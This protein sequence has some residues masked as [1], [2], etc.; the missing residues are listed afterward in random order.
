M[1]V[2]TLYQGRVISLRPSIAESDDEMYYRLM[3]SLVT[4][5]S[6]EITGM[7]DTY[8][9][10]GIQYEQR[11]GHS[12]TMI[13]RRVIE[14]SL[15][16]QPLIKYI[17][18]YIHLDDSTI[19]RAIGK[20]DT[21]ETILS[22][23]SKRVSKD[24]DYTEREHSVLKTLSRIPHVPIEYHLNYGNHGSILDFKKESVDLIDTLPS[25]WTNKFQLITVFNVLHK[26]KKQ[27]RVLRELYRVLAP[28]GL[29]LIHESD[30]HDL[31]PVSILKRQ[32]KHMNDPQGIV[33]DEQSY[34]MGYDPYRHFL[35]SVSII[36]SYFSDKDMN[37]LWSLYRSRMEWHSL[38]QDKGFIH[39]C[40]KAD[41]FSN[42]SSQMDMKIHSSREWIS[43]NPQRI[44]EGVYTKSTSSSLILEYHTQRSNAIS[45][46]F[47]R[48]G[49]SSGVLPNIQSGINYDEETLSYMTPWYAAQQ[50][51]ILISRIIQEEYKVSKYKIY[52]GTGGSGGNV[53]AYLSNPNISAIYVYERVSKFFTYLVNNIQLYTGGSKTIP[54]QDNAVLIMKKDVSITLYNMEFPLDKLITKT[55]NK[56]N[57]QMSTPLSES[58]LFLDVPWIS[59]GCGYKLRG[60]TYSG[61]TLEELIR[62]VLESGAYMVVL[63]LPPGYQLDIRHVKHSIGKES[64][65]FVY[66]RLL[67]VI[68]QSIEPSIQMNRMVDIEGVNPALELIRYRLMTYLR[69]K[70]KELIPSAGKDDYYMWLYERLRT[71]RSQQDIHSLDPIIPVMNEF[72]SS[73][74]ITL[75]PFWPDMPFTQLS[76]LIR[77]E[78]PHLIPQLENTF[79]LDDQA[80]LSLRQTV[81][82][83]ISLKENNEDIMSLLHDIT[84]EIYQIY[85]R[86]S[87]KKN[88]SVYSK[89][90][91]DGSLLLTPNDSLRSILSEIDK[92]LGTKGIYPTCK[93]Y[94][95]I[96]FCI[97][98]LPSKIFSL[99]DRYLG[100]SFNRDL[101]SL[102]IR[103]SNVMQ[104]TVEEK[105]SG[106]NL[107]A[108]IPSSVFNLIRDTLQVTVEGF[109]SP[110]NAILQ[111]YMSAFPDTD[112]VFGSIGSFF[113][114]DI[115]SGSYELNPPFTEDMI[116]AMG[117]R[118]ESL[119]DHADKMGYPLSFFIV[120]PNWKTNAITRIRESSWKRFD[121][122]IPRS[123]HR[124]IV[125]QQHIKDA[126]FTTMFD[127]YIAVL[128]S[129]KGMTTYSIPERF[130]ESLLSSFS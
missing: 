66:Q 14:E 83:E 101:A 16:R 19:L 72:V 93:T 78:Y 61:Y 60:Y 80:I 129:K 102:C 34:P 59:E 98:L 70:F 37:N 51:S 84:L 109:A 117:I 120:I 81:A 45:T 62:I 75:E 49:G 29:L 55:Y 21:D 123:K 110:F 25:S 127:T 90:M 97:P 73:E 128:Q 89:Y 54:I 124:F 95:E 115:T 47:P 130:N 9:I 22:N 8:H 18:N 107:H 65:Y 1:N 96:F 85:Q 46:F 91:K 2:Y 40:T 50:T 33:L 87:K 79:F 126:S 57:R 92:V 103:Y 39:L 118:C 119:L 7:K 112:S 43:T 64:L 88:I 125:G 105:Y 82:K 106:V 30:Y 69:S 3:H 67:K 26:V 121:M 52:D 108:A 24:I 104:L 15:F 6:P 35:D 27:K 111:Q 56:D 41:G 116:N 42:V 48:I 100:E 113:T 17:Q 74:M 71:Y 36:S 44:F 4:S 68:R 94:P 99:K 38:L 31:I 13:L 28:G 122:I 114:H 10:Y 32:M 63:K 23:L 20:N 53:I 58:V 76:E 11:G 86:E 5:S 77:Q 12:P